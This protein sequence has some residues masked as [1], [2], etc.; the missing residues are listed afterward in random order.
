MSIK[1]GRRES[2]FLRVSGSIVEDSVAKRKNDT[3]NK[4]KEVMITEKVA[5]VLAEDTY[6]IAFKAI[7]KKSKDQVGLIPNDWYNAVHA[8][9][10]VFGIQMLLLVIILGMMYY[11]TSFL[12]IMPTAISTL[13]ARF[14][15]SI[16]MHL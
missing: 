6:T 4:M 14:V 2:L 7:H 13:G 12:I 3:L 10:F 9:F 15:C 5:C 8:S 1:H 11:S 16:L